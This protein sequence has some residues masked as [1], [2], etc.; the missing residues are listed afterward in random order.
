MQASMHADT[1]APTAPPRRLNSYVLTWVA[2]AASGLAYLGV[3]AAR[4]ALTSAVHGDRVAATAQ[5]ADLVEQLASTKGWLRDL[6]N[7]LGETRRQLSAE[8]ERSA[9]LTEQLTAE[10][11]RASA[12]PEPDKHATAVIPPPVFRSEPS[13]A[14]LNPPVAG[15][16]IVNAAPAPAPGTAA[17]QS[18]I[19][20]GSV[21]T[22]RRPAAED[23][24]GAAPIAF[25]APKVVV[26]VPATPSGIEIADSDSLDG[27]RQSWSALSGANTD[28]LRRLSARYRISG[29]ASR[30]NPFTL[31]AGPFANPAEARKACAALKSRGVVCRV[32]DFAG[33]AM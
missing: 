31:L 2:L 1:L 27:L 19:V 17:K 5:A 11:A 23:K 7:E 12:M 9:R 4:P 14:Q 10:M 13:G 18:N 3:V 28:V 8:R 26:A 21:E 16:R 25:G 30:N 29:D 15:V 20:T 6:E 22:G 33:N 24:V 32:G